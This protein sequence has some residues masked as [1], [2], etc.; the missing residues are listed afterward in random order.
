M[1]STGEV[2]G[3]GDTFGE[4]F[5]KAV[6]GA[7]ESIPSSG[8]VFV[9]VKDNDKKYLPSLCG[10]LE[11]LGFTIV[12]TKGTAEALKDTNIK[13]KLINKVLEGRPHIVDAILN[14]EIDM[15][16]NTTE[17]KRSISD[18][19][20]IRREALNHKVTYFTTVA[21]AQAV[22]YALSKLED[23]N[24]MKIKIGPPR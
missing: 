14:K 2:M 20:S 16:I 13:V 8:S 21:G 9:S 19:F 7:G 6:K 22:A 10:K 17:G 1:K 3:R 23:S 15:I 11:K 4:A 12:A 18:S 5:G 24:N